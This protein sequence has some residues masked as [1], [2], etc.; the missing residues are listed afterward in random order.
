MAIPSR[1]ALLAILALVATLAACAAPSA[2]TPSSSTGVPIPNATSGASVAPPGATTVGATTS[3]GGGGTAMVDLT[4]TGTYAFT[5]KG[6]AGRCIL[7]ARQDGTTA[8]GFEATEADYPG[9][10]KSYSMAEFNGFADVKWVKDD[11][12]GYA[13]N[14]D[15]T[16]TLT[17]DH[18]GVSIDQDLSPFTPEG[19][20]PAGPE[21]VKGTITCP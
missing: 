10:G 14:I 7:F 17:P 12:V 21:H 11:A 1:T 15:S 19:G 2:G 5:A 18:R 13:N 8:F 6:T 9:L 4:F 16:I 3:G 20:V